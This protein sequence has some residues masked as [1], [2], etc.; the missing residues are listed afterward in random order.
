MRVKFLLLVLALGLSALPSV[1]QDA[2]PS[3]E[4]R[5]A[6]AEHLLS[7]AGAADLFAVELTEHLP[8]FVR[9]RHL[10]S[11]LT[12]DCPLC[13]SPD[14]RVTIFPSSL[15]RGDDVGCNRS[16]LFG[17]LTVYATR[18]QLTADQELAMAE[19]N[20]LMR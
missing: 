19:Q 14:D 6:R 3:V 13:A 17:P 1:A 7:Q 18:S 4:Q 10:R 2:S 15:P 11:A 5:R 12:C 8:N 9:V 16:S 20:I